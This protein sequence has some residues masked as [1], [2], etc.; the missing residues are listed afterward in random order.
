MT[1]TRIHRVIRALRPHK[2]VQL[3]GLATLFSVLQQTTV[4]QTLRAELAR[5]LAW[6][7]DQAQALLAWSSDQAQTLLASPAAEAVRTSRAADVMREATGRAA[8][9]AGRIVET[10]RMHH[11]TRTLQSRPVAQGV[12]AAGLLLGAG[13]AYA[14]PEI[15]SKASE[16]SE[17][18]R[19]AD[20][21]EAAAEAAKVADSIR[22][23]ASE[24]DIPTDELDAAT[25]QLNDLLSEH[26]LVE[27]ASALDV[28]VAR[29][30]EAAKQEAEQAQPTESTEVVGDDF[31]A[32]AKLAAVEPTNIGPLTTDRSAAT[33]LTD[34]LSATANA[35][36][37]EPVA[38][39]VHEA[40]DQVTDLTEKV[41]AAVGI[42]T[43]GT[44]VIAQAP[45]AP[46][47]TAEQIAV[48][49]QALAEKAAAEQA[50]A[51]QAAAEAAAAQAAAEAAAKAEAE[52]AA[53]AAKDEASRAA[54]A[55][56]SA[57]VAAEGVPSASNGRFPESSLCGLTFDSSALLRCDAAAS[58]ELMNIEYRQA[59]G[60]DMS[61]T[62]SYRSYD[63][64]VRVKAQL[65]YLAGT[66]G[67]S[68]H[69]WARALDLGG[70]I[71]TF[72]SPQHEWMKAN[73]GRF[74]WVHPSWA[75]QGGSKPEAWHW[76]YNG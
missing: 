52:A 16:M 18:E 57:R 50:A 15:S 66:P 54:A 13:A 58:L 22:E 65:G 32:S 25:A 39:H 36:A 24:A 71:Q 34:V 45:E 19:L 26:G 21:S 61:I 30:I 46:Q 40:L 31:I 42:G 63:A 27:E 44:A 14:T 56:A 59:F 47:P 20:V 51:E 69:G 23:A 7:S 68:N 73:A 10:V 64:Q 28:E 1:N 38:E 72:G 67:T 12:L 33:A 60:T 2:M 41:S 49:E 37:S 53:R 62:D 6:S 75:Q 48:A 17:E 55:Q 9:H 8:H 5:L 11:I 70:G 74:G 3:L 43:T 35:Y 4:V 76:E 29:V